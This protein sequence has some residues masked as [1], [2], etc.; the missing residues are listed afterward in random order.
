MRRGR[1][2]PSALVG[3]LVATC[4]ASCAPDG[5]EPARPS[6]GPRRSVFAEADAGPPGVD[7][8]APADARDA[9]AL[10][11]RGGTL[12]ALDF[13]HAAAS[14]VTFGGATPATWSIGPASSAFGPQSDHAF[15]PDRRFLATHPGALYASNEDGYAELAPLDLSALPAGCPLTLHLWVWYELEDYRDGANL[16]L[17]AGDAP[18]APVGASPGPSLYDV[19]DFED[20]DCTS[21]ACLLRGQ[22]AWATFLP[23]TSAWREATFDVTSLAGSPAAHLRFQFHSDHFA[24]YQGIYVDDVRLTSP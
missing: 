15:V 16:V 12:R 22:P 6:I 21:A 11:C 7:A 20:A 10:T 8:D 14:D 17:A 3:V 18:F 5:S 13:N 24:E 23:G 1:R 9:S 19:A 2:V 4:A